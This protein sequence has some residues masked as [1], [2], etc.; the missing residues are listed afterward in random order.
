MRSQF[1]LNAFRHRKMK[2]LGFHSRM[3][4]SFLSLHFSLLTCATARCYSSIFQIRW[5]FKHQ[6]MVENSF[7]FNY[8]GYWPMFCSLCVKQPD[9]QKKVSTW[10]LHEVQALSFLAL[11]FS[12]QASSFTNSRL[13][14]WVRNKTNPMTVVSGKTSYFISFFQPSRRSFISFL[15]TASLFFMSLCITMLLFC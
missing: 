2:F 9:K 5:L 1:A 13:K 7:W 8:K 12:L 3:P 4:T 11:H 6:G 14:A 10:A 15:P